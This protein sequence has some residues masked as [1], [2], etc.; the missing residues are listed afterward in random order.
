M[1]DEARFGLPSIAP[2]MIPII[3]P[4]GPST[5]AAVMLAISIKR[6]V[7]GNRYSSVRAAI[8]AKPRGRNGKVV[9]GDG[10]PALR[11]LKE[12]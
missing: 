9:V 5:A 7:T 4:S 8:L 10:S 3:A 1:V 11:K 6:R 12:I 2:A